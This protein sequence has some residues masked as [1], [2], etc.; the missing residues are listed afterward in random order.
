MFAE[1]WLARYLNWDLVQK[2]IVCVVEKRLTGLAAEMAFHAMLGLFPAIIA[3]LTAISLFENTVAEFTFAGFAVYF[4]NIVPSQVWLLLLEFIESIRTAESKSWFSL[5]SI[6][7]I[8]IIS[9]VLTA[10][11]NALDQIHQY[12]SKGTKT[13]NPRM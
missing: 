12:S 10:A 5:S 9:G 13:I 8:W 3:I 1:V 6:V 2:T 7:A 4:A 11:I